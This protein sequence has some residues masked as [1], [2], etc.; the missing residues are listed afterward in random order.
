MPLLV[1]PLVAMSLT[2]CASTKAE[3]EAPDVTVAP[4]ASLGAEPVWAV[5]PV[6]N[7]SGSSI[8]NAFEITDAIVKAAEEA[9]GLRALPLNRVIAAMRALDLETIETPGDALAVA[10]ALGADGVIVGVVT[11][12]DPYDPP[13]LGLTLAL[14][15]RG[16]ALLGGNAVP[17]DPIAL[18]SG[19]TDA[20]ALPATSFASRPLSTASELLDARNHQVLMDLGEY[21][22]GRHDAE[23]P[24]GYRVYT[25][26]MDLYTQFVATTTIERLLQA[27][28]LRLARQR[29]DRPRITGAG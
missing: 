9:R 2:G 10:D 19:A 1:M 22:R 24:L 3:L 27:E 6:R 12:Y 20:G 28:R 15:G 21:A 5:V 14:F 13:T 16:T 25:A 8:A 29:I 4:Y 26:R 11:A 23:G 7:E 17:D 18:V